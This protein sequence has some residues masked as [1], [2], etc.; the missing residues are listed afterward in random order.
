M[1]ELIAAGRSNRDISSDLG[2]TPN[3]VK[4]YVADINQKLGTHHRSG[5]VVAAMQAGYIPAT[6]D[7]DP[8]AETVV[9]GSA[10][11]RTADAAHRDV[12]GRRSD[13]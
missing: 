1:T 5:L 9:E 13:N 6:L 11:D 3:T 12:D 7:P 2:V 4:T 10:A 8:M